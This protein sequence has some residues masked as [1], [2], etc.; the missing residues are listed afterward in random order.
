VVAL[1]GGF[2][3][4]H[5][6]PTKDAGADLS[7]AAKSMPASPRLHRGGERELAHAVEHA[8]LRRGKMRRAVEGD[9]SRRCG[10]RGARRCGPSSRR[11]PERP[12]T[13]ASK[14]EVTSLPSGEIHAEAAH[15]DA[16]HAG[17]TSVSM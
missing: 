8:Q 3:A 17:L 1:V 4:A 15:G 5:P 2:G 6:V 13:S 10:R 16:L 7:S 9:R 12:C 14:N 11:M